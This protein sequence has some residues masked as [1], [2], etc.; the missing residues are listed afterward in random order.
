VYSNCVWY[1]LNDYIFDAS[2]NVD[3]RKV[4][5]Q[6]ML[7]LCVK[8]S[9]YHLHVRLDRDGLKIEVFICAFY[10]TSYMLRTSHCT[11]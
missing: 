2:L 3:A 10:V 1:V 5:R 6:A 9:S 11:E 8:D 7:T 4:V